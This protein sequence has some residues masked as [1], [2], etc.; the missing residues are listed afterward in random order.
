M[1]VALL[2]VLLAISITV[3]LM[4]LFHLLL[5]RTH[6]TGADRNGNVEQ[7][8][9]EVAESQVEGEVVLKENEAY[10]QRVHPPTHNSRL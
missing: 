10:G 1:A 3:N 6:G 9:E 5:R 2:A 7:L 4:I 8:Y